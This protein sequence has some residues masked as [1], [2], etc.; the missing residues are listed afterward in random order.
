GNRHGLAQVRGNHERDHRYQGRHHTQ[1]VQR[2]TAA[3]KPHAPEEIPE[4][5]TAQAAAGSWALLDLILAILTVAVGLVMLGMRFTGR[6]GPLHLLGVVPALVS[7]IAFM[8]TSDLSQP[9]AITG[10]WT[11]L[12]AG[13]AVV[14]LVLL[15]AGRGFR[16]TEE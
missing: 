5:E 4:E 7:V 12:M 11:L 8:I 3:G 16:S 14:Q 1:Q 9:M 6:G 2:T 13:L 15:I 10:R